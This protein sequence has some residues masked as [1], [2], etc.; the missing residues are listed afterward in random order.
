M[1]E[2]GGQH[3]AAS[4]G[5]RHAGLSPGKSTARPVT[6]VPAMVR[7]QAVRLETA[8][9]GMLQKGKQKAPREGCT[10]SLR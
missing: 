5:G 2:A 6:G 10:L 7:H 8:P 3:R 1:T 9:L 4:D